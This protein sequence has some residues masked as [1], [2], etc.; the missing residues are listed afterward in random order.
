MEIKLAQSGL[1]LERVKVNI[2]MPN[3]R[4]TFEIIGTNRGGS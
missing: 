4:K 1:K 3:V 2:I